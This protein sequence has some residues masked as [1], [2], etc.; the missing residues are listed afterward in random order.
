MKSNVSEVL[1]VHMNGIHKNI[2]TIKYN[3][4]KFVKVF[5][6]ITFSFSKVNFS[7][8]GKKNPSK[9]I[10]YFNYFRSHERSE[11][12]KHWNRRQ[13]QNKFSPIL[14]EDETA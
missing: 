8:P 13:C 5:K 10:R 14:A 12:P 7:L 1:N 9:K 4:L 6:K 11:L 2:T 3:K